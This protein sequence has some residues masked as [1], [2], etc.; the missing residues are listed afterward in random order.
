[1]SD[2]T[3]TGWADLADCPQDPLPAD[4]PWPERNLFT[5]RVYSIPLGSERLA[6]SVGRFRPGE[7]LEL[8]SHTETEEIYFLMRGSAQ[9][10]IDGELQE[11]KELDA[12]NFPPHVP[13]AIY[14][15]SGED[16]WWIFMGSP[17]QE[18]VDWMAEVRERAGEQE[19]E[20]AR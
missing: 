15:N 6:M 14:N 4:H 5:M 11:A 13:R 10:L 9:I 12:F 2:H 7:S 8:H 20:E 1:M 16:C 17:I 18:L 19:K 3:S